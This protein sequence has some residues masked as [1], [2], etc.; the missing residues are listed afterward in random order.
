MKKTYAGRVYIHVVVFFYV[1]GFPISGF[2]LNSAKISLLLIGLDL[3]RRKRCRENLWKVLKSNIVL[4]I[5]SSLAFLCV[6]AAWLPV[7]K[8]TYDFTLSYNYAIFIVERVVGSIFIVSYLFGL[9]YR[10]NG[11]IDVFIKVIVA[12]AV[13][14]VS[15]FISPEVREV[16]WSINEKSYLSSLNERYGGIR[17]LGLSGELAYTLS[18]LLSIGCIMIVYRSIENVNKY[19]SSLYFLL[20]VVGV[21]FSGRTGWA[22]VGL[23]LLFLLYTRTKYKMLTLSVQNFFKSSALIVFV[24]FLV[25]LSL[26]PSIT[27]TVEDTLIP[28][29]FEVFINLFQEGELT[30]TSLQAT[31]DMYFWVPEM[32]FWFGDGRFVSL[33]GEDHSYYMRTDPG[34]MRHILF[35]GFFG[36]SLLYLTYASIPF[37]LYSNNL[38]IRNGDYKTAIFMVILYLFIVHWKGDVLVGSNSNVKI[39]F[40]LFIP[41][42]LQKSKLK[43]DSSS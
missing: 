22:G 39:L 31:E 16:L 9:G 41:F 26:G 23:S 17:G 28:F 3:F 35:Y 21:M 25:Y 12:Q 19:K 34:Y 5:L 29:A 27:R 13:L 6:Y 30:A 11:V 1:F 7:V 14:I 20:L 10:L 33:P 42:L 2:P 36:S 38:S 8:G 18:V 43:L 15:M 24:A 4:F 40:L 37:Y 32:S